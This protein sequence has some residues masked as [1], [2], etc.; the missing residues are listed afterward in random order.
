[1]NGFQRACAPL[2]AAI[3]LL[4]AGCANQPGLSQPATPRDAASLGLTGEAAAASV[5]AIDAQWWRGFGDARLD[6]LVDQALADHPTL[7]IAQARLA[8]ARAIT[9][10]ADAA[11]LPQLTASADATRQLYTKNGAVP[12]PLAGAIRESGTLQLS[13]GWELDFFGKY[14]AALD[15]ALGQAR[16]AQAASD[17]A[18]VLLAGNVV[19]AW[20][21]LARVEGQTAVAQRTLAQREQMLQLVNDRVAAGID[22]QLELRQAESAVPDARAQ[23]EGLREQAQLARNAIAAL[24]GQPAAHVVSE[25]PQLAALQPLAVPAT[26]PADL[27]GRRADVAAARARVEAAGFDINSARAQFYPNV[28]LVAF[29]GLSSIGLARL[30]ESGSQQWGVGPAIRLPIF[31]A[32]RL[33]ANLRTKAAEREAAV[34][35]YDATV[36]DAVRE[37]ADALASSQGVGRQQVQQRQAAQ[38]A[39]AAYDIAMQRYRAGIGNYLQ[40]LSA[41]SAVLAQRRAAVELDARALEA[42][43]ALARALGGGWNAA[44]PEQLASNP[45]SK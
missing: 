7:R 23:L 39:E 21:A 33:R 20:L 6:A 34:A 3:A 18:R 5:P 13:A 36:I 41:E 11:L 32:G 17:A 14:R 29:A 9:G 12:A 4:L 22:S 40:V 43:A 26:I 10:A 27:L 44:H 38:A 1:M 37:A 28:N 30:T 31:D 42:Q 15:A 16:A 45:V 19:R 8:Q 2:A 25:P 35:T 24:V